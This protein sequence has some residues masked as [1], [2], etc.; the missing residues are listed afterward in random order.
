MGFP[1]LPKE[2]SEAIEAA[3]KAQAALTDLKTIDADHDG[4]SDLIEIVEEAQA[5]GPIMEESAIVMADAA[6]LL[7]GEPQFA[8]VLKIMRD[9]TPL[10]EDASKH[11]ARIFS[12]AELDMKAIG[13]KYKIDL[14]PLL[15]T[16]K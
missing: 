16:K 3:K 8:D 5:L 12:L 9:A 7:K 10:Y 4:K 13:D 15:E 14:K 11:I 6:K 1:F 2:V